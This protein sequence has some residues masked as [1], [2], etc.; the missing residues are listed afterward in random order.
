MQSVLPQ[1]QRVIKSGF[2]RSRR[3]NSQT[4]DP[5]THHK[6]VIEGLGIKKEVDFWKFFA[7]RCKDAPKPKQV[8]T[9]EVLVDSD[10]LVLMYPQN[11]LN[12]DDAF[13]QWQHLLQDD[14]R[15]QIR[16]TNEYHYLMPRIH[17][18]LPDIQD[19]VLPWWKM[20]YE[21]QLA[22]KETEFKSV[23]VDIFEQALI[24]NPS[25]ASTTWGKRIPNEGLYFWEGI[26]ASPVI[27]GFRNQFDF[28]ISGKDLPGEEYREIFQKFQLENPGVPPPL[29][30]G[31]KVVVGNVVVRNRAD[32]VTQDV[33]HCRHVPERMK[34]V[35]RA[36]QQ[37]VEESGMPHY[38]QHL[39]E[40]FWRNV[41]ISS[42]TTGDGLVK[43]VVNKSALSK[44]EYEKYF[45]EP[46]KRILQPL[47]N[48]G[49]LSGVSVQPYGGV[50][51]ASPNAPYQVLLGKS[52]S[53]EKVLGHTFKISPESFFQTNTR[54]TDVAFGLLQKWTENQSLEGNSGENSEKTQ[55]NLLDVGCGVG[56]IGILLAKNYHRVLGFDQISSAVDNAN[57]NAKL[58]GASNC[59]FVKGDFTNGRVDEIDFSSLDESDHPVDVVL[60]PPRAGVSGELLESI[61]Y[62][63]KVQNIYYMACDAHKGF[64]DNAKALLNQRFGFEPIRAAGIDMFPHTPKLEV[65]FQFSRQKG[66][67]PPLR[68]T[69]SYTDRHRRLPYPPRREQM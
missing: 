20:P 39:H 4:K 9:P 45:V 46:A 5:S 17:K 53:R 15:V 8:W 68:P 49:Y 16:K 67:M 6:I 12:F 27:D 36:V 66:F 26:H 30:L 52:T 40:G 37:L 65:L 18:N 60:D 55:R 54:A 47:I 22:K 13:N 69:R 25:N 19:V 3:V 48:E 63:P 28:E 14:P 62:N 2:T 56:I 34:T 21:E 59:I 1:T 31:K 33:Q 35:I 32:V 61:L 29:T 38:N 24:N 50:S 42:W 43:F 41:S 7:D 58:N 57:L 44:E 64:R 11:P 51:V 10:K 23:I